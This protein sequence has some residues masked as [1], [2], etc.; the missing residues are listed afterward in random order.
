MVEGVTDDTRRATVAISAPTVV[1][2]LDGVVYLGD[3]AVPGAREALEALRAG[4]VGLI[5]ATNN[6][7]R[8]PRAV[9]D[10]ILAVTG[11]EVAPDEVVTSAQAAARLLAEDRPP[12][13]IVGGPGIV[14]ALEEAGVPITAD[15]ASAGAVVAGI[16]LE[17]GYER[18]RAATTAIREGARFV[19]TNHD[20]T[21]PTPAGLWP[22]AGAIVAALQVAS[23]R[24]AEIA[25]KPYEPMRRL[26]AERAG[27]GEVWVV[28]DRIDTDLAMATIEGWTG[29]LVL[30]G[31]TAT[32]PD[33]DPPRHVLG[34][35]RELPE[36]V[37]AG[38]R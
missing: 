29:V 15:P 11:F 16:D 2:D 32:A 23:G 22:G 13:L 30:T 7:W 37:S 34:S 19:A 31:V 4:G 21:Y 9:A 38:S 25:G 1:C 14:A 12:T 26:I 20:P 33:R 18:L 10:R 28:G 35:I 3:Q 36:L 5:F 17:L 24:S 8:P 27:P 6:S